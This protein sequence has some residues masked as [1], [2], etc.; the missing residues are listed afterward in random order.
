MPDE[1]ARGVSI[2]GGGLCGRRTLLTGAIGLAAAF[3]ARAADAP[4]LIYCA[5]DF[6][7]YCWANE[8]HGAVG[9][10]ADIIRMLLHRAGVPYVI[11]PMAW[12][13]A[14]AGLEQGRCDALFGLLATPERR[15]EFC[16]VGSFRNGEIAFAVR[17]DSKLT[18]DT[19]DDLAG[20]TVGTALRN[21]Y[22]PA[23][24]QATSFTRDPARSDELSLLKLA[25]GRVDMVVG[26]RFALEW[27]A[28]QLGIPGKVRLLPKPLAVSPHY[29]GL[30][31]NRSDKANQL[32]AAL[33]AVLAE[34]G[35]D[36]IIQRWRAT[37]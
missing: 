6:P 23:F 11:E 20:L 37:G 29:I 34:G 19:L 24:D 31:A 30:P 4:W 10:D 17:E 3:S 15:K 35:I 36:A 33:D 25:A 32:Q 7:P 1:D 5:D 16:M 2:A 9:M 22:D 21:Q 26:D 14:M 28:R 12:S 13:R 27:R 18:F 8:A